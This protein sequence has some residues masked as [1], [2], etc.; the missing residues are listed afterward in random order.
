MSLAAV[1]SHG[2]LQNAFRPSKV[3][4]GGKRATIRKE[5]SQW[6]SLF[7]VCYLSLWKSPHCSLDIFLLL[8]LSLSQ[9]HSLVVSFSASCQLCF[10]SCNLSLS[11]GLSIIISLSDSLSLFVTNISHFFSLTFFYDLCYECLIY[12]AKN[13]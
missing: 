12:R 6:L 11:L 13:I 9:H 2:F 3:G 8:Q 10:I 1:L 4:C 5:H 7:L